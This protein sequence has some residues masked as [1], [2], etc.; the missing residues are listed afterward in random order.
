LIVSLGRLTDASKPV[1]VLI[2][3][4]LA[5]D[6]HG[7]GLQTRVGEVA[8]RGLVAFRNVTVTRARQA[9]LLNLWKATSPEFEVRFINCRWDDI[10]YDYAK[11]PFYMEL[12]PVPEVP[13]IGGLRFDGCRL[14]LDR[15][16]PFLSIVDK[17]QRSGPLDVKG[18]LTVVFKQ[19]KI[20]EPPI[21]ARTP[22]LHVDYVRP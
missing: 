2:M 11:G 8:P 22:K 12:P 5:D 18:D 17:E 7:V 15:S 21:L 10:A 16:E 9:G 4:C 20:V 3:D 1:S 6:N 13:T 14:Y 19:G